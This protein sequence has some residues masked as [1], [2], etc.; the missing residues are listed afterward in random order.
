M[1][2]SRRPHHETAKPSPQL[3]PELNEFLHMLRSL[4]GQLADQPA[5]SIR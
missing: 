3:R 5:Q 2:K 1:D 4:E